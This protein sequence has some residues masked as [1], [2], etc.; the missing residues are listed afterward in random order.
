MTSEVENLK[1]QG[2]LED[3]TLSVIDGVSGI[4]CVQICDINT[5]SIEATIYI[6]Q[7]GDMGD[8][9]RKHERRD[10]WEGSLKNGQKLRYLYIIVETESERERIE[11]LLINRYTPIFNIQHT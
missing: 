8:R 10:D 1:W 7:A 5:N 4:Y 11:A 9:I 3:V 6:G 2:P